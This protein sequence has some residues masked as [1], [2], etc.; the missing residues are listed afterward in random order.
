[1]NGSVLSVNLG[2]RAV[3]KGKPANFTGI[4]KQ[5]VASAEVIA[6]PPRELTRGMAPDSRSG[7]VGDYIGDGAH[8]GGSIQ[9]VYACAREDLDRLGGQVGRDFPS[10]SFGENLTT[11]A[12]DVTGALIGE[13]WRI[14]TGPDA[15]E[16]VVTCPRIPCNTFRAWIAEKGWL[17]TFT[18]TARPGAYL[19]VLKPGVVRPGDPIEVTFRPDHDVTIGLLFRSQTLERELAPLVL[20]AEQYLDPESL[21][22]ARRGETFRIG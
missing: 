5:P 19:A 17:K 1:M 6:P 14:G 12:L 15:T 16:L 20:T 3:D 4:D 7:L 10:G 9:A 21:A 18:I 2:R 11:T 8:H 22:Y 13:Q